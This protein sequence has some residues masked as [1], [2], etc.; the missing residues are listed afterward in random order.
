MAWA[1]TENMPVVYDEGN[2]EVYGLY[3]GGGQAIDGFAPYPRSAIVDSL[4]KIAFLDTRY[5]PTAMMAVIERLAGAPTGVVAGPL[6]NA[7]GTPLKILWGANP[8]SGPVSFRF[9]NRESGIINLTLFDVSGKQVHVVASRFFPAGNSSVS[10][11]GKLLN[12]H[13]VPAGFYV[14]RLNS[15]EGT[16]ARKLTIAR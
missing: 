9:N 16:W 13:P 2:P 1:N 5:D 8:V 12:G 14:L 10:W 3:W 11:N 15:R 7:G 6:T 4:G